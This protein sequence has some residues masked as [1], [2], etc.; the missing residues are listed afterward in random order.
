[1]SASTHREGL[2]PAFAAARTRLGLVALLFALAGVAWWSTVD[3]M[4]GM[5]DG[6]G[7]GLGTFGW[8]LGTWLVMMAAMMLPSVSPT[9]ALYARMS[10]QRSP[11]APYVFT[12]GYL[13]LWE[14]VGVVAYGLSAVAG[15]VLGNTLA[16]DR[17]GHWL[18]GGILL[19]A[20][21]Y[22]LTPLKNMCLSKCRSPLGL[23][24]GSWRSGLSGAFRM[25]AQHGAWCVGCCWALMAS[26]FALG[27]MSIAWMASVAALIAVEK[28]LPWRR[29]SRTAPPAFSSCRLR[30]CT[31][32][33]HASAESAQEGVKRRARRLTYRSADSGCLSRRLGPARTCRH[34]L[35]PPERWPSR[36]AS[37]S[38]DAAP[39][40]SVITTFPSE[41]HL[42]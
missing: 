22:E 41:R 21:G 15:G 20:A 8:F 39:C 29:T 25:G 24:L 17:A 30:A 23:L 11:V 42:Y 16:W 33:R 14:A 36:L 27:V 28:T 2:A 6:P 10:R 9:V 37:E 3:Q 19:A 34:W 40:S 7:T 32:S 26:L 35:A 18:A 38:K 31:R 12:S 1:V 4:R 5:D 13:V